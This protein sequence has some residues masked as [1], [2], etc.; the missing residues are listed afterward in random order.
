MRAAEGDAL[1]TKN[2]R[3]K[4]G[5]A[6]ILL[7]FLAIAFAFR[8]HRTPA[9]LSGAAGGVLLVLGVAAIFKPRDLNDAGSGS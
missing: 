6:A 4:L 8:E 2:N 1:K 9:F 5:A 3:S 7:A